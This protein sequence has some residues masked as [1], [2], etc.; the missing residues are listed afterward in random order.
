MQRAAFFLHGLRNARIVMTTTQLRSSTENLNLWLV[1]P[2]ALLELEQALSQASALLSALPDRSD[3]DA[4]LL[5]AFG[6]AGTAQET[7]SANAAALAELLRGEGLQVAV[8][9]RSGVELGGALGAYAAVGPTGSERIYLNADWIAAGASA[10]TI[11]RVLLEE[12]GHAIDQRLNGGADAAG[13]EGELFAA[14]LLGEELSPEL[15]A[16]ITTDDDSA[17]LVIDGQPVQVERDRADSISS[18]QFSADTGASNSDFITR[19]STQ[20]IK[21]Q[22]S[23]AGNQPNPGGADN[24]PVAW[25]SKDGG[26]TRTPGTIS[27][28]LNN[29]T[30]NTTATFTFSGFDLTGGTTLTFWNVASGGAA[31]G[32]STYTLD[33]APPTAT[34]AAA[35]ILD[36]SGVFV[37]STEK[38]TAYLVNT[39]VAVDVSGNDLASIIDQSGNLWNEVS[40]EASGSDVFL[41]AAGLAEGLYRLYTV[42][43][44]G[45]LSQ[46]SSEYVSVGI[47]NLN[48]IENEPEE[49]K[50]Q[51]F[52]IGSDAKISAIA[53]FTGK[54][55]LSITFENTD[56]TFS[57]ILAFYFNKGFFESTAE[58]IDITVTIY[59]RNGVLQSDPSSVMLLDDIIN[60]SDFARQGWGSFNDKDENY[61]GID[62]GDKGI[63][64]GKT[65]I[66]KVIIEITDPS[67]FK[68]A[69]LPDE[70]DSNFARLP[71]GLRL[72]SVGDSS[73]NRNGSYFLD[74]TLLI[75]VDPLSVTGEIFNEGSAHIYWSVSGDSGRTIGFISLAGD[76]SGANPFDPSGDLTGDLEYRDTSG[77]WQT[78]TSTAELDGS[79]TLLIRKAVVN[80]SDFE[81]LEDFILTVSYTDTEKEAA[82]TSSLIDNGTGI[83]VDASGNLD[84]SGV[85][86]DDDRPLTVLNN[87]DPYGED[88]PNNDL[89]V[90]GVIYN[91]ASEYVFWRIEGEQDQLISYINLEG[92][93]SG[94]D[95]SGDLTGDLE[96]LDASGEW[97]I[98]DASNNAVLEL[99]DEG[100]SY[101]LIRKQIVNDERSE[102]LETFKLTV[103]NTGGGEASGRV[104]VI[105]NGTGIFVDASGSQQAGELDNDDEDADGIDSFTETYL[106][107]LVTGGEDGD[108]N[109]DGIADKDQPAFAVLAWIENK[110]F[111]AALDG[112]LTDTKPII[113]LG[114]TDSSG[115]ISKDIELTNIQVLPGDS[116]IV[117]GSK[118]TSTATGDPIQTVWDP[119]TFGIRPVSGQDKLT[120]YDSS[121]NGTQVR[122]VIDISRSQ[123]TT[124]TFDGFVK[125]V[126]E[127]TIKAY[128]DASLNLVD[129]DG[130]FITDDPGTPEADGLGA[131][132]YDFKRRTDGSGNPVGNGATYIVDGSGNITGIEL[133]LTDN[134]FGDIDPA[135]NSIIDPLYNTLSESLHLRPTD[136]GKGLV[137][138][139]SPGQSLWVD[140]SAVLANANLQNSYNLIRYTPDGEGGF[141]QSAVGAIGATRNSGFLGDTRVKLTVGE[142]LRFVLQSN[143]KWRDTNPDLRITGEDNCIVI[144]LDDSGIGT[145]NDDFNDL[146]LQVK[147]STVDPAPRNTEMSQF[148]TRMERSYLDLR[149][150]DASGANLAVDMQTNSNSAD[151]LYLVKVDTDQNGNPLGTVGGL[152][153][154]AGRAFDSAVRSNLLPSFS[155]SRSSAGTTNQILTLTQ[156]QAG[157]YAPVVI[158]PTGRVYTY[159]LQS[160]SDRSQHVKTLGANSF[161]FELQSGSASDWGFDDLVVTFRTQ[162]APAV[163]RLTTTTSNGRTGLTVQGVSDEESN[164]GL[165]LDLNTVF[166]ST[167]WQNNLDLV[168]FDGKD[169]FNI[170]T[171]GATA[172]TAFTGSRELFLQ[173]GETLF[174]RENSNDNPVSN[175]PRLRF[176]TIG[177]R[178]VVAM[179]DRSNGIGDGD[180]NDLIVNIDSSPLA[181]CEELQ[182]L[183]TFQRTSADGVL[184][185]SEIEAEGVTVHFKVFNNAALPSSALR[186]V[187][188]EGGEDSDPITGLTV[189]S[190]TFDGSNGSAFRTAVRNASITADEITAR[191]DGS[192]SYKWEID[193]PGFYA[194]VLI[195]GTNPFTLGDTTARDGR[196]HLKLLGDNT[197]GFEV[198]SDWRYDD[199]IAQVTQVMANAIV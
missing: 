83:Y 188:L 10:E 195:Y 71:F 191:D 78:F 142:E 70:Q 155:V 157:V 17:T 130:N 149:W 156:A 148:Q 144:E 110:D 43:V 175:N 62:L 60:E 129:L 45:N 89:D 163:P 105:D 99:D 159:G 56:D 183:T 49:P 59:D 176:T 169:S 32:N 164:E 196:Q 65:D 185:L 180:F 2:Q 140:L 111:E 33:Q 6:T 85:I 98:F 166:A 108:L 93:S 139:G 165:W 193:T 46:A 136:D 1:D 84:P 34:L 197:F 48:D 170:G 161:G 90:S 47:I 171:V 19:A 113:S 88:D 172:N 109:G 66:S 63:G 9:L 81:N 118:P 87:L 79:G 101:T 23:N 82:G 100:Q 150:I 55:K 143:N 72:Q 179:D 41:S 29:G 92:D 122:V 107:N 167:T 126:S 187:K 8:E 12:A 67:G 86:L 30:T 184:D 194:P 40:I 76:P 135:E 153:P 16:A 11:R 61:Y 137:L 182:A 141:S 80:D 145:K 42:D 31:I 117:G 3:G 198:G 27:N 128:A 20:T 94:A 199:L 103:A 189:N 106:G 26:V 120:D 178:I 57:D 7:F 138:E 77:N 123:A 58:K 174:F 162:E 116:P 114:V 35:T 131:G 190:V 97:Q 102:N 39:E 158:T 173:E 119:I 91:E 104:G 18:V 4:L 24:A 37:Q 64:E 151:I 25:I 115:N 181:P 168:K 15:L 69:D 53:K 36:S 38:G 50:E 192:F 51:I 147:R 160:S 74:S 125:Y 75:E 73:G 121:R 112:S 13:D 146:V 22:T 68:T 28:W 134:E 127:E 186:L 132:W 54:T 44:A 95:P 21:I 5:Q 96:Y 152:S 177:E 14:L 52:D 154:S 133:I 124:S